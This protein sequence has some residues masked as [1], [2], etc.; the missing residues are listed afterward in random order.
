MK[1]LRIIVVLSV[2]IF[3]L[4]NVGIVQSIGQNEKICKNIFIE[5]VNVSNLT[6]LEAKNKIEQNINNNKN[7][8][9]VLN[10]IVFNL[11]LDDIKVIYDIDKAIEEAYNI[12]RNDNLINNIKSKLDL[13]H[14]NRKVI[15]INYSY[16]DKKLEEYIDYICREINTNPVDAS[17]KL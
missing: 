7:L 13:K 14:G 2:I 15:N 3:F 16:D 5:D 1:R 9:L 4:G 6:K 12:G 17:I 8:S 10:D 11:N